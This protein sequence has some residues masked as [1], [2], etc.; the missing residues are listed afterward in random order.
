MQQTVLF[1]FIVRT[2]VSSEQNNSKTCRLLISGER[3]HNSRDKGGISISMSVHGDRDN[4][5]PCRKLA[6]VVST[7]DLHFYDDLFSHF[8][9]LGKKGPVSCNSGAVEPMVN[10]RT[11]ETHTTA[12]AILSL[13]GNDNTWLHTLLYADT[14]VPLLPGALIYFLPVYLSQ[15]TANGGKNV[16]KEGQTYR[17]LFVRNGLS[18]YEGQSDRLGTSHSFL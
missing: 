16:L 14:G 17:E 4:T 5:S 1:K 6:S 2:R 13:R 11:D 3:Y 15:Y 12:R 8:Y 18:K 7:R 9:S 10:A